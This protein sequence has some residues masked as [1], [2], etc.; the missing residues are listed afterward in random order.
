[1]NRIYGSIIGFC[2]IL[3][4]CFLMYLYLMGRKEKTVSFINYFK[5]RYSKK[6]L[7]FSLVAV[8]SSILLFIF[9][10]F[11]KDS[12]L[13]Q[14]FV[15]A[16]VFIWLSVLALIDWKEKIIP[17]QAILVGLIFWIIYSALR[18]IKL[19]VPIKDQLIFS[20]IGALVCG[21]LL[22][23]VALIAKSALG[24]G[25]VK[26]FTVIGLIY[27]FVKAY[28]ILLFTMIIMAVVS[29]ILLIAK[30]VNRKT[31]VPMAPFAV[32]GFIVSILLGL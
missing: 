2:F 20:L 21:G 29:I 27:G 9:S 5:L 31:A 1:M 23:V 6:Y 25:D 26:M 11:V 3:I 15:N 13:L 19:K 22:L 24:M 18:V 30:K 8:V 16:E 32:F 14:A 4:S 28:N 12:G 10:Y 17:N 7:L